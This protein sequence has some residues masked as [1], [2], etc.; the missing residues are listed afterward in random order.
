MAE[1]FTADDLR[2]IAR[3]LAPMILEEINTIN[4]PPSDYLKGVGDIAAFLNVSTKTIRRH[5]RAKKI[6]VCGAEEYRH[7]GKIA[8]RPICKKSELNRLR[9]S[10]PV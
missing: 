8:M 6:P 2:G 5:V 4:N 3:A 10:F 9:E 7:R 1:K